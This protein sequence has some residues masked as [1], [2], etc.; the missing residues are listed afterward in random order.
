MFFGINYNYYAT[1]RF[2]IALL[3]DE[4]LFLDESYKLVPNTKLVV[5]VIEGRNE[6]REDWTRFSLAN[7]E[8]AYGDDEPEYSL[9]TF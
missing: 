2:G 3:Q 8:R 7:L 4:F 6:E 5:T 1:I 9:K